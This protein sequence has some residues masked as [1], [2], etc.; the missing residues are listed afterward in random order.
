MTKPRASVGRHYDDMNTKKCEDWASIYSGWTDICIPYVAAISLLDIYPT[1]KYTCVHEEK[2]P[3]IL[4]AALFIITSSWEQLR[5]SCIVVWISKLCYIHMM[6]YY[7][8][9]RMNELWQYGEREREIHM[10]K[11]TVKQIHV[12]RSLASSYPERRLVTG[13][14]QEGA[15]GTWVMFYFLT[16]YWLR[17]CVH[18]EDV[19]YN[20]YLYFARLSLCVL[21]SMKFT[22]KSLTDMHNFHGFFVCF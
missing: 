13:K 9:V 19:H 14:G 3:R 4:I 21:M 7:T 10:S 16:G 2:Y 12:V 6:E 17:G 5:Y 22:L 8:A 18:F 15:S 20:V 1:E 11:Q